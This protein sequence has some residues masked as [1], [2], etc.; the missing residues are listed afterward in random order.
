ML[1]VSQIDDF[2]IRIGVQD[3]QYSVTSRDAFGD[4]I[5][6]FDADKSYNSINTAIN[7]SRAMRDKITDS[8]INFTEI[9]DNI[10]VDGNRVKIAILVKVG[11]QGFGTEIRMMTKNV[12]VF[13]DGEMKTFLSF[14]SMKNYIAR[15]EK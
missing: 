12:Q 5:K 6:C 15:L 13:L 10:Y 14:E 9:Q 3:M 11:D 8:G 2:L 7:N 1:G 4:I